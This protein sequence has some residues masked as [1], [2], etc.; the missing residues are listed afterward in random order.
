MSHVESEPPL[1]NIPANFPRVSHILHLGNHVTFEQLIQEVI[2]SK[3]IRKILI[4]RTKKYSEIQSV[5]LL[6]IRVTVLAHSL[7]LLSLTFE[8]V[9]NSNLQRFGTYLQYIVSSYLAKYLTKLLPMHF[10]Q[11]VT[12]HFPFQMC[13]QPNYELKQNLSNYIH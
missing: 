10:Y 8:Q 1:R 3:R 4:N 13:K 9:K 6:C 12:F 2:T 5:L 11:F 7:Y